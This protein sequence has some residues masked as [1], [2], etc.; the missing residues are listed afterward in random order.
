MK[1][2][3]VGFGKRKDLYGLRPSE[4]KLLCVH[5]ADLMGIEAGFF[6]LA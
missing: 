1:D 3:N 2:G 4:K 5:Q 6:F